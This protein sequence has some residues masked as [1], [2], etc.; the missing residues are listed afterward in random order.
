MKVSLW[1]IVAVILLGT[2]A[3]MAWT[4]SDQSARLQAGR[5][6][7][8]LAVVTDLRLASRA[9]AS[10]LATLRWSGP[11]GGEATGTAWVSRE[12]FDAGR[13]KVGDAVRVWVHPGFERPVLGE[14]EPD[15]TADQTF[16][17]RAALVALVAGIALLTWVVARGRFFAA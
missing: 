2:S 7:Q 12:D 5:W 8:V 9:P 13:Y 11:D 10:G 14:A 4:H 15:H 17:F 16:T 6:S 1:A 3:M